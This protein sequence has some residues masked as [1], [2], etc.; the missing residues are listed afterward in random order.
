[1]L[2]SISIEDS[3]INTPTSEITQENADKNRNITLS[4]KLEK[5]VSFYKTSIENG[6][7]GISFRGLDFKATEYVEDGI[8][9]YRATG[10]LIDTN[11][12]VNS[13]KI[14]LNDGS[15]VS[16]TGV[17]AMGGEVEIV[18]K[19]P[20]KDLEVKLGSTISTN[21]EFYY[22][23]VGSSMDNYYIQADASYYNRSDFELSDD[24]KATLTQG[25]G[26][27]INSDKEQKNISL[28]TGLFVNDNLHVAIKLSHSQAEYGLEPNVYSHQNTNPF[29]FLYTRIDPKELNS[30]Y[31]YIDY[32]YKEY[33]FSL[34]AYY[35]DYEDKFIIYDDISYTTHGDIV[36]Y[37]DSRV[38]SIF[39]ATRIK[40]SHKS[41]FV[42]LSE[43]N[44]HIR[45]GGSMDKAK[46]QLDTFKPSLLHI[47]RLSDGFELE[48]GVSYTLM[49]EHK[50][51]E[52]SA[53]NSTDDKTAL[54]GL[55]KLA[56]T[57]DVSKL[58]VSAA[59]KSRMPAMAE[60]FT[61]FI[62]ETPNP[63][64]KPERSW[65]YSTGYT[66]KIDKK[67]NINLELY[68]YDI[69]DL[70][71]KTN[72]GY[73][74]Q[75]S[76]EHY[77]LELRYNT[78]IIPKNSIQ[79][80]YAYARAQDNENRDLTLIPKNKVVLQDT[81]KIMPKLEGFLSYEYH[82]SQ[83]SAS[84]PMDLNA[85]EKL[86]EYHLF[87]AQLSYKIKEE[88]D[89]RVGVKNIA[90]EDYEWQYGFPAEGRSFY[91]SLEWKI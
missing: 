67:S 71:V 38:G 42:F 50:A 78:K 8:P 34:R 59:R 11:F 88:I 19:T 41:S 66:Y 64:L 48:G 52:G 17:S 2:E 40:G 46:T 12:E 3:P 60:M 5:D 26:K 29:A 75:E 91:L 57:N 14:L 74:N 84:Y 21:D 87:D 68:Y 51:A 27:R 53:T 20:S 61:F 79:L 33:A 82:S 44:E 10:G 43:R 90:D 28:K 32:D 73:Q 45:L 6:N 47:E 58:Y 54:D 69:E 7:N 77:G 35:D 56:Y 30:Y 16:S 85:R 39:K 15:G 13:E 18:S 81:I 62:W 80:A 89:A 65:Q 36:T 25:K 70:I 22:T 83:Y 24:Y 55:V 4:D 31:L 49:K 76:A 63:N 86:S 1:M 23:S 37:D 9:L 72:S